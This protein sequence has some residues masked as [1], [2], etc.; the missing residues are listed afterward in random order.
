MLNI[1]KA[2]VVKKAVVKKQINHEQ[3]KEAL[4]E[5]QTFRH[6]MDVLRSERH[7]I[8]DQHLN[9]VSLSSFDSKWWIAP[10]GVNTLAYSHK[11]LVK[12]PLG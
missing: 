10:D 3:Y 1:K 11:D 7:R 9:K 2:K 6:G 12:L 5:K 8:Y 4:F